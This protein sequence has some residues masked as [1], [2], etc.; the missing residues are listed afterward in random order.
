[1][2]PPISSASI[3]HGEAAMITADYFD[4][5]SARRHPV[6]LDVADAHIALAGDGIGRTEAR[7]AV[8][9]A[10][11]SAGAP[12]LLYL[13]GGAHCEVPA[14]GH[15][16]LFAAFGYRPTAV[17]RW[18]RRW[19]AALVSVVLM[20]ALLAAM[21]TWG[22]PAAAERIA[23]AL[24]DAVDIS[25]GRSIFAAMEKTKVTQQSRLSDERIAEVEAIFRTV[26]PQ[27][28]RIP[29]RLV[30]R[31]MPSVGTNAFAL[32]DGTVL[33]TDWMVRKA[34]EDKPEFGPRQTAAMAGVLAHEIG[35]IEHRHSARA[36]ARSSLTAGLS[37][38]LFG[39]FSAVVAGAPA[40]LLSARHSRAMETEADTYAMAALQARHLPL[41]PLAS[42]LDTLGDEDD[43]DEDDDATP[44]WFATA[45]GYLSS[46]PG[47][48]ARSAR[49]RLA[50]QPR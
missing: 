6:Q 49:L 31:N 45:G 24:P 26:L 16:A 40:V 44:Y 4:G 29:M 30:I 23:M 18:Q 37:A 42:L 47:S 50:D 48:H 21:V 12:A 35:H 15:A 8:R 39:D 46:H 13:P 36:L 3:F 2:A 28:P 34:L 7:G 25:L 22:I 32:P 1:M 11:P 20:V 33:V 27:H 17:Q 5:V 38:A 19:P 10:E 14:A 41:A 43:D 9:L